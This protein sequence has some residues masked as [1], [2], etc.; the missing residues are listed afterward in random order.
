MLTVDR[1]AK[2]VFAI[3]IMKLR[4]SDLRVGGNS[5]FRLVPHG[6]N[7]K[8]SHKEIKSHLIASS[9]SVVPHLADPPP[10]AAPTI[11]IVPLMHPRLQKHC[12]R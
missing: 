1:L 10:S 9:V 5:H 12:H 8:R 4:L 11:L 6:T 3:I 2:V 7:L